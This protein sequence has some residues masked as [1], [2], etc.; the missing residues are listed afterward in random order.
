MPETQPIGLLQ[1]TWLSVEARALRRLA[2]VARRRS[3]LPEHLLTGMDGEREAIFYL[4]R[5]GYVVVAR[6]WRSAKQ[7][8]DLDLVA[9]HSGTLCFVE[10][11][12]RS[13]RDFVP[14]EAA[15]DDDK[16][17]TLQALARVYM[18]RLPE[19]AHQSPSRFDVLSV[20][21]KPPR[22]SR[23]QSESSSQPYLPKHATPKGPAEQHQANAIEPDFVLYQGAFSWK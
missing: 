23:H 9:W 14:A 1:R 6:R 18:R 16:Q 10:I 20:Y 13:R 7:R 15:V 2:A 22:H 3:R 11:K 8:G 4:R 21:M 17:R 5:L 19:S 12:T